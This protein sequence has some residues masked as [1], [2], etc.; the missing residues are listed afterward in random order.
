MR[1]L[2]GKHDMSDEKLAEALRDLLRV[3]ELRIADYHRSEIDRRRIYAAKD[4]LQAHAA[5]AAQAQP[6]QEA[7]DAAR[8]RFAQA[9]DGFAVC[10]WDDR[11]GPEGDGEYIPIDD[12][13]VDAAMAKESGR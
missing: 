5:E 8:Y 9:S 2:T 3:C 12:E 1:Y 11:A 4:A 7:K 10:R 13:D 6:A